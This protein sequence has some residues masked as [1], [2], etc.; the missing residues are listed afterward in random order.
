MRRRG[1]I[2]IKE[3]M[4]HAPLFLTAKCCFPLCERSSLPVAVTLKRLTALFLGLSLV[5]TFEVL[6]AYNVSM[7]KRGR[8]YIAVR[9]GAGL[10]AQDSER[11]A[12]CRREREE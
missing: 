2:E 10:E 9:C 6:C 7:L 1:K 3:A 12:A 8:A 11:D 5:C 4:E